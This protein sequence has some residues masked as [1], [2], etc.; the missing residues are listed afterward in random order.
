MF[1]SDINTA[2]FSTI[3]KYIQNEIQNPSSSQMVAQPSFNPIGAI[4]R[5]VGQVGTLAGIGTAKYIRDKK[6]NNRQR[7]Q[8]KKWENLV[9]PQPKRKFF[10][11]P[12][13]KKQPTNN[14]RIV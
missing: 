4:K 2:N 13:R 12:F 6:L 9:N 5:K 7:K 8:V 3:K 1:L 10:S 14:S 11:N